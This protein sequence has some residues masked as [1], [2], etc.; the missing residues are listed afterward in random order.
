MVWKRRL[1]LWRLKWTTF[2]PL[3]WTTNEVCILD[4]NNRNHNLIIFGVED[5]IQETRWDLCY[6][7]LEIFA[8]EL[9]FNLSDNM[10][11]NCFQL[12]K[13]KK[14]RPI[15]IKFTSILAGDSIL[16]RAKML[17]STQLRISRDYDYNTRQTRREL[18]KYMIVQGRM[19]I[20]PF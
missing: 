10:I 3:K 1:M 5:N 14:K 13:Q 2:T 19:V 6:T 7:I 4:R 8:K 9:Q 20:L 15:L 12:G 18:V 11:D 16:D 17:H